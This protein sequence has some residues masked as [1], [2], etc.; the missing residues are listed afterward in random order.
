MRN[1]TGRKD[2]LRSIKLELKDVFDEIAEDFDRTRGQPWKECIE[3]EKTLSRDSLVLDLGCGNGRNCV[4][5]ARNH[6]VVGLDISTSMLLMAKK[7]I[8]KNGFGSKCMLMQSDAI[9][10][11]L[12]DASIEVVYYIATLHH[13]PSIGDRLKSLV[14]LRRILKEGGRALISVWAF[15]QPKF[16]EL[17]DE[18]LE[19][20]ERFGD[21]YIEWKSLNGRTF[22]RFYHLFYGNELKDLVQKADLELKEH[23][24]SNDNY[25][26]IAE[27]NTKD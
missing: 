6:R 15:D 17:L 20:K 27:K 19:K 13:I 18:H 26:A 9:E 11:P 10:L 5:L 24:K 22:K 3:F 4:F 21:V 7:N 23:A 16:Q 8:E 25:Y 1:N 14:E 2:D 12:K